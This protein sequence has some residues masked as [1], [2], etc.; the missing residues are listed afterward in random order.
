MW[1]HEAPHVLAALARRY[2]DFAAA[3]DAVQEALLAASRQ[4]PEEGLP[5]HPR[6]WL[7]RVA[8]RRL[9]DAVRSERARAAR[10]ER[11]VAGEDVAPDDAPGRDHDDTLALLLLCC[12]PSLTPASQVALCLRAVAGFT[13]A[14]VAAAFLVPEAT[15]AQRV[16]RAK[17]T[18]RDARVRLGVVERAELPDRVQAVLH[19]LYLV[20]NEGYTASSGDRLVDRALTDEAVRLVRVLHD[21]LPSHGEVAGLL[22]LMLLTDA[23]TPARTDD[24]GD[25]VPLAAQ[26]RARWRHD[27]VVEGT[28][29]LERVLPAGP[30]GPYAVQAAIAAVH[31]EAPTAA[32]TDWPQVVAL[33]DVLARL[34]PGRAVTLNRAVA[35]GAAEGADAGL[36]ALAPLLADP[37]SARHHR[38]H[39]VRAQLLEEAGRTDDARAAYALAARLS[40]N[41]REQRYLN[42]RLAALG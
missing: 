29:L 40:T 39:A 24:G 1:R 13:T 21:R 15:A 41:V 17:A 36:A 25:L 23:R 34:T 38:T 26:D 37:A 16:S 12:H 27:L 19:V 20:F 33:Y 31:A 28:A 9:V 2:G 4:W 30:P 22:A 5:D 32:A 3:E 18:L 11:V 14:Q 8:Q 6:G 7:L 35:V 10:E 42:A